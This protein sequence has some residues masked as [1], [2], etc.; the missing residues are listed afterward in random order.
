MQQGNVMTTA[1]QNWQ[2]PSVFTSETLLT[3]LPNLARRHLPC[4]FPLDKNTRFEP[5]RHLAD[6]QRNGGY[7]FLAIQE[8]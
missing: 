8:L 6:I 1:R 4:V 5:N 3:F 2:N 7:D